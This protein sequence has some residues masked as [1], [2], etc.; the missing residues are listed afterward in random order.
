MRFRLLAT[1]SSLQADLKESSTRSSVEPDS[2]NPNPLTQIFFCI[3]DD[4]W[5]ECFSPRLFRSR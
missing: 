1:E 5:H 3:V 4:Y 2:D